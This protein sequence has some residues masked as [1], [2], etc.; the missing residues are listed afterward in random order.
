MRFEKRYKIRK[1][2]RYEK[3]SVVNKYNNDNNREVTCF[4]LFIYKMFINV[5]ILNDC[6]MEIAR[7]EMYKTF[8]VLFHSILQVHNFHHVVPHL[9]PFDRCRYT[10]KCLFVFEGNYENPL[11]CVYEKYI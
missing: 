6:Q 4:N 8:F 10:D 9:T 2:L 3:F 11:S 1:M 5:L 7:C